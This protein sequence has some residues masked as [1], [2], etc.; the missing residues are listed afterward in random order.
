MKKSIKIILVAICVCLITLGCTALG[1][2]SFDYM[3]FEDGKLA[4]HFGDRIG[5]DDPTPST[6]EDVIYTI[7]LA[8]PNETKQDYKYNVT[9]GR[10]NVE[11]KVMAYE[12]AESTY[13][14]FDGWYTD[15]TYETEIVI[16]Q[17]KDNTTIYGN[18]FDA[19]DI[20]VYGAK[21]TTLTTA[22]KIKTVKN[23]LFNVPESITWSGSAVHGVYSDAARE[24]EIEDSFLANEPK[25]IYLS[26][27]TAQN[28]F[29]WANSGAEIKK[30]RSSDTRVIIPKYYYS[31]TGKIKPI[32]SIGEYAFMQCSSLTNIIIP[33]NITKIGR[34]AFEQTGLTN[35]II[36]SGI[37]S[38]NDEVFKYCKHLTNIT[39]T[40]S[41]I[42]IGE[43]AFYDCDR[44]SQIIIPD[45]VTSIGKS[46]FGGC[47]NLTSVVIQS[48]TPPTLETDLF[49]GNEYRIYVPD[50]LVEAYKTAS[51]WETYSSK[52]RAI[53]VCGVSGETSISST[54]TR[55][56]D[57]VGL[58]YSIN[59]STGTI[60]SSFDSIFPWC[61]IVEYEYTDTPGNKFMKIPKFY[62][63]YTVDSNGV[64]TTKICGVKLDDTWLLNPIFTDGNG[65]EVNYFCIG[66]YNASLK[67]SNLVSV[68]GSS[69]KRGITRAEFR[70]Y[71]KNN[72]P[73][74]Q[75]MDIWAV[76]ALQDLFKVEFATLNSQNIMRGNVDGSYGI[77][78]SGQT[79]SIATASGF[80]TTNGT[81]KYRGIENFYGNIYQFVDGI[82]INNGQSYV[83]YNPT[84]YVDDT[85]TNYTQ[86]GY[87][88]NMVSGYTSK[89]G[90]D[91]NNP[92]VSMP[93]VV[94]QN[95]DT[96]YGDY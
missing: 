44:L 48:T 9:K 7:H 51:S 81:M 91:V 23:S 92:F 39:L 4:F 69:S 82:N 28:Q 53:K 10:F 93:T 72:G 52:I 54:L 13:S 58:T 45:R 79:D 55:T 31:A 50:S 68:T 22:T 74:Y 84:E 83:C 85:I 57:A 29:T 30:Y 47:D 90:Y 66:K 3:S 94:S 27:A 32:I 5:T 61:D 18:F 35:I 77:L 1:L 95:N 15:E 65:N 36:P 38:I 59:S 17:L 42:S 26:Y 34:N 70:N 49:Y 43:Y 73:R 76:T 41:I 8:F 37:T 89:F 78:L 75:I 40:N 33:N 60:T 67:G 88:N 56:D 20:T 46:A 96:S 24:T 19:V 2:Y 25:T 63:Q 16:S 64:K 80:N 6:P 86:L 87:V 71:A 11:D 12:D 21:P 14:I 62:T